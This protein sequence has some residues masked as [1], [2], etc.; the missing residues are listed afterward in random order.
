M[1]MYATKHLGHEPQLWTNEDSSVT[2]Q[3]CYMLQ[4]NRMLKDLAL[5]LDRG[6]LEMQEYGRQQLA[7]MLAV[8]P[9]SYLNIPAPG[10]AATLSEESISRISVWNRDSVKSIM[11]EHAKN[12]RPHLCSVHA[13]SDRSLHY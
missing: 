4:V 1:L 2:Y 13:T 11:S 10:C 12:V 8:G 6:P 9:F 5:R 7:Q 3:H